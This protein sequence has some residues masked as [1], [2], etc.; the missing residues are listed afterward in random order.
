[1]KW[2]WIR[3]APK[4]EEK[5][6]LPSVRVRR[7]TDTVEIVPI[8]NQ[9]RAYGVTA[10]ARLEPGFPEMADWYEAAGSG[11]TALCLVSRGVFSNYIFTVGDVPALHVLLHS[12]RLPGRTLITCQPEHLPAIEEHYELEWHLVAK[13]M[14]VRRK[15]FK[16]TEEKARRL[17]PSEIHEVNRLYGIEGIHG[18]SASRVRRGVFYG[19]WKEGKLVAVAGTHVLAPSYGIAHVGNVMTH[20]D[21]RNQGLAKICVS[22]VTGELL[23]TCEDVVLDVESENTPAVRAY[24]SLGYNDSCAVVEAIGHRK[25]FVGAIINTVCR[26]LGLIP[27][28][29]EQGVTDG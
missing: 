25:S 19:I 16:P 8:L 10:F 1:M 28:R 24:T 11:G 17:K 2:H 15:T 20:P 9:R 3:P 18:F 13:R 12:I 14:I 7:L 26:R 5:G 27:P 6:E 29:Y 4:A 23:E 21:F 22:S